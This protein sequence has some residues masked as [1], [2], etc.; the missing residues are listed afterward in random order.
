[1]MVIVDALIDV[2]VDAMRGMD[3]ALL[4]YRNAMHNELHALHRT[5]AA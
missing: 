5:R 3:H 2:I 4:L 1:M